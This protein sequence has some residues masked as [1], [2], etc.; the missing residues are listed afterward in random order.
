MSVQIHDPSHLFDPQEI[1]YTW[2]FNDSS[3]PRETFLNKM[4]HNFTED[5]V[6]SVSVF[7][8]SYAVGTLYN[9]TASKTM[10]FNGKKFF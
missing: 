8:S 4:T 6:Y 5:R 9:G 2:D 3:I 1:I 7:I 10:H